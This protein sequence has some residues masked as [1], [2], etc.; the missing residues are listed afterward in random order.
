MTEPTDKN[1]N[2]RELIE[3]SAFAAS[4]RGQYIISQALTIAVEVMKKREEIDIVLGEPSNRADMEFLRDKVF[5][6]Y[7]VSELARE[8]FLSTGIPDGEAGDQTVA[9]M[10]SLADALNQHEPPSAFGVL[11]GDQQELEFE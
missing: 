1:V 9:F 10:N 5:P 7:H 11:R 4:L 8:K 6:L 2:Q 3:A